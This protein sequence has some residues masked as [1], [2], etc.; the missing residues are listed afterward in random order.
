MQTSHTA[1]NVPL[2]IIFIVFVTMILLMKTVQV[3][4]GSERNERILSIPDDSF[5]DVS[6]WSEESVS[7]VLLW[8]WEQNNIL[9]ISFFYAS[10]LQISEL[11]D[12][13]ISISKMKKVNP[14]LLSRTFKSEGRRRLSNKWDDEEKT[15]DEE[16]QLFFE[17][18]TAKGSVDQV[19][20]KEYR[21][22]RNSQER[23]MQD[24]FPPIGANCT[25]QEASLKCPT[26]TLPAYCD[27][28]SEQGNF[29]QCYDLCKPSYCCVHDATGPYAQNCASEPNCRHYIPCYI[30]WWKL[31]DTI[32]PANFILVEQDDEFYTDVNFN[33][34]YSG[35]QESD[36]VSLEVFYQIFQHHSDTDDY[37]DTD[38]F[39][40]TANWEVSE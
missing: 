37:K 20:G 23:Q 22:L 1:A 15:M 40:D 2:I 34:I 3:K 12:T 9:N 5:F 21:T 28:Y 24:N 27:K 13:A 38:W 31:A 30:I 11:R 36:P 7:E 6:D 16:I 39:N 14:L 10:N 35:W 18:Q 32:G 33:S 26:T 17:E 29:F 4:E 19:Q 8:L 25:D